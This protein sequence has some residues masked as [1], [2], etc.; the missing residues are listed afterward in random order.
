MIMRKNSITLLLLTAS[1][2]TVSSQQA[3]EYGLNNA[4]PGFDYPL[5]G[6]IIR[7]VSGFLG[8]PYF[9]DQWL[10][11]EVLLNNG[12]TVHDK[13]LRYNAFLDEIIWLDEAS[14]QQVKLDRELVEGFLLYFPGIAE[15]IRFKKTE[16]GPAGIT[17]KQN[18]F[19][20]ILYSDT[21]S[22]LAFRQVVKKRDIMTGRGSSRVLMSELEPATIYFFIIPGEEPV[23]IARM[24]RRNIYRVF[25]GKREFIRNEIRRN[26]LRLDSDHDL[27]RLAVILNSVPG[28]L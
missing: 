9:N 5:S 1:I 4:S 23:F 11:G 19:A 13:K 24:S 22:L 27:I 7:P 3:G 6:E 21:I 16:P 17:A 20:Q 14:M 12:V 10:K 15:P 26:N 28:G 18:G 8:S 2:F 25:P